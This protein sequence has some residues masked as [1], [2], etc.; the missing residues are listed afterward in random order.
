MDSHCEELHEKVIPFIQAI[1]LEKLRPYAP[2]DPGDVYSSPRS[3]MLAANLNIV[4]DGANS[5]EVR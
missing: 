2:N 5:E 3:Q 4:L 1:I